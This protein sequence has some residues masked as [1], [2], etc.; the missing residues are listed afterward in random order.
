MITFIKKN[1]IVLFSIAISVLLCLWATSCQARVD[2]PIEP[3]K[4][5]TAA[6]LNVEL[7]H[8][9]SQ[10][11]LRHQELERKEEIRRLILEN[12]LLITQQTTF[13]PVGLITSFLAI[14]GAASAG[15]S[16]KNAI[17]HKLHPNSS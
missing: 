9:I 1:W 15:V 3:G 16:T 11:E 4:K 14:Y 8:L 6:E 13:N 2:S 12:A 10:Y 5:L 7:E 17:K